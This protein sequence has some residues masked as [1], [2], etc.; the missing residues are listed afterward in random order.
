MTTYTLTDA[1]HAAT[2]EHALR[3]AAIRSIEPGTASVVF[4][5]LHNY[6]PNYRALVAQLGTNG[7]WSVWRNGYALGLRLT[8][9][10][11]IEL[12]TTTARGL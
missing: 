11:A 7:Q 10:Q 5:D 4:G 2:V 6:R 9:E 12:I 8:H 1:K 3:G